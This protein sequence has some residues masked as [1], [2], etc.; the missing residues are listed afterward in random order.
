[1][2]LFFFYNFS[3]LY[4]NWRHRDVS[5]TNVI[6]HYRK[7][8]NKAQYD[9]QKLCPSSDHEWEFALDTQFTHLHTEPT[10]GKHWCLCLTT[11]DQ[12]LDLFLNKVIRIQSPVVPQ[13]P[14][15]IILCNWSSLMTVVDYLV[16][17]YCTVRPNVI[18]MGSLVAQP[19]SHV[20]KPT[21]GFQLSV[22]LLRI[23][24]QLCNIQHPGSPQRLPV[25]AMFSCRNHTGSGDF[26]SKVLEIAAILVG[27]ERRSVGLLSSH[28][29][30]AARSF[31]PSRYD[32]YWKMRQ[33]LRSEKSKTCFMMLCRQT[34]TCTFTAVI[35]CCKYSVYSFIL[36]C[37]MYS[38][39]SLIMWH[40]LGLRII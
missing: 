7:Y 10:H 6:I 18:A 12:K 36:L 37:H 26:N 1:M 29:A 21:C 39:F 33:S 17:D 16:V 28:D 30:A 35:N 24:L 40:S 3:T 5:K 4:N 25:E 19:Q 9:D 2:V 8:L 13:H 11:S 32:Y 23:L 14:A 34:L 22:Q 27:W 15:T 20:P 38:F 31:F